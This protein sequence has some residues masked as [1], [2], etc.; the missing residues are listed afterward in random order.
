MF[1]ARCRAFLDEHALGSPAQELDGD[2][3]GD[4]ALALARQFQGALFDAGLAGLSLPKQFGGQGLTD[5]HERIWREEASHYPL[6]TEE[7]SISLG[8]CLPVIVE[9]GTDEQKHRHI[10]ATLAGRHVLC[11]MFSEPEA[12]S[13]VASLRSRAVSTGDGWSLTGQKVW[14]TLAHVAEYGIVLA[15]TDPEQPKHRGLS[16][17]IVDLNAPGVEVRPIHQIDGGRH[18][19]EV[20]FNDV[21]LSPSA[22]IPPEN[23][24]WRLASAMLHYQRVARGTGQFDGI[25][26]DRTDQLLVEARRRD[27]VD[28]PVVRQDLMKLY[29]AEVCR[30]LVALR[31]R[32][33]MEAS[34]EPGPG[35]SLPKL[36][37]AMI[38]A[39]Y[40]DLALRLV[41]PSSVAWSDGADGTAEASAA[42]DYWAREA[43][44]AVSM[45]ISGGTSEIQRNIIGER[46]LGL[47]R[48]PAPDRHIPFADLVVASTS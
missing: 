37:G 36:A 3:R 35:G 45:S 18:F 44:F 9:F 14:T 16:L 8:N 10:A 6:I 11:Q 34:G 31:A 32:A 42:G 48:E 15:R 47:P 20:F 19:N 13:D 40:R 38:A 2:P 46:V 43:L 27:L 26:H 7:L 41:G 39:D 30:S 25:R 23:G 33:A 29:T 1:R 22:L 17:F 21:L 5:R 28:D 12:G 24:G 4:R